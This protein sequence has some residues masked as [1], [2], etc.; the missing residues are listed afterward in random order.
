MTWLYLSIT[1]ALSFSALN[2]FSRTTS[3]KSKNP[4]AM[5]I[6][7]NL[8]AILMTII[9]FIFTKSYKNFSLPID[10]TAYLYLFFACLFFGLYERLRFYATKLVEASLLAIINNV[11]VVVAFVIALLIYNEPVSASKIFGFLL[12]LTSLL[13]VSINKIKK[14]SWKG[15]G[16]GLLANVFLGIGW[17]FDKKGIYYFNSDTYNVLAWS[18]PFIFL[19]FFPIVKF[20]EIKSEIKIS[21]WK[22]VLLAFIN[23]F[24]YLINL[25]AQLIGEA[26]KV[27]PI[28]QTST[29]FTVIFSAFILKE[30]EHFLRKILAGLIAVIGVFLLV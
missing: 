6:I 11:S 16:V 12:I 1:S 8:T 5:S 28:V 7:F 25:K 27:I 15:I 26:T 9:I 29:L 21:S 20:S 17:A 19:Y 10:R 13:L 4:R 2:I 24:G 3:V 30:K 23:V 22:I 14:I 18:L